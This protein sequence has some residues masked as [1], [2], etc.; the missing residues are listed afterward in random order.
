M[1]PYMLAKTKTI[2]IN[3][4]MIIAENGLSERK[5]FN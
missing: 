2:D 4:M 1:Q 5:I 3:L